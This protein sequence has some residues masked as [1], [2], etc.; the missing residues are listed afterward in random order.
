VTL[1]VAASI[2]VGVAF[3]LAGAAKLAAGR[4]WPTQARELGAPSWAIPIVPWVEIIV[5]ALLC[6]QVARTVF[7]IVAIV[8]LLLFTGVVLVQLRRGRHPPCA[9]FGS[10]SAKPLGWRHVARN[11]ALIALAVIAATW[12]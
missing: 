6:A 12:S 8:L 1:A 11:G 4:S 5:G 10:W 9:C 3:L 7:A 2:I